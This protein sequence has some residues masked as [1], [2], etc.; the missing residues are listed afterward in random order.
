MSPPTVSIPLKI[1][2]VVRL[3]DEII[4][5]PVLIVEMEEKTVSEESWGDNPEPRP[6]Y[7]KFTGQFVRWNG[8]KFEP[9]PD[10]SLHP[11]YVHDICPARGIN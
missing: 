2:D 9:E 1:G 7:W 6:K 5:F 3:G 11:F 8:S 4:S 10:S